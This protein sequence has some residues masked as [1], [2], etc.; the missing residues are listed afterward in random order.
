MKAEDFMRVAQEIASFSKDPSTK[1]GAVVL[2][3][4]NNI[5]A[6]GWNGFPR[7]VTDSEDRLCNRELK[8]PLTVHAEAN[9]IAASART[10]RRLEGATLVVS[11]LYPC[12]DCAGL[13]I[14]A[15]IKRVVA[16]E[17]RED[18]RWKSSNEL[19]RTMFKEAGVEVV[20]VE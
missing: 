19:A 8:Y 13:I 4:Y 5:L 18:S 15:G 16:A 2:D 12:A 9:A 10:G 17:I 7:G 14:Q 3:E 11:S 1:V 6:T 20:E